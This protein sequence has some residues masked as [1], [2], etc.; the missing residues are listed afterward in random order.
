VEQPVP[1][2]KIKKLLILA[3]GGITMALYFPALHHEFLAYDDQQYVTENSH[4]QGGLTSKG[5]VWAFGFH[6]SNWHPA[7]WISHMLDC[8]LYGLNPLGHHLT[9]MLLHSANTVMLFL[10]L[11]GMTGTL[12]RS[13]AVAALFAWH[14]L[15]VESVAW[16]AER[17]DVLCAFFSLV[18]FWAYGRYV[19]SARPSNEKLEI[20][21]PKSEG[22][23]KSW[24]CLTL[25]FFALALMSK[26]MVVT[27]PFVLLLLDYWPL[28]RI[29]L[30]ITNH[31]LLF[32]LIFEKVPFLVLSAITCV[33][34]I[35]AQSQAYAVVSTAGLPISSRVA[36][37]LLSYLHYI[38]ALFWP[39]HLAVYYPYETAV[40]PAG[41]IGAASV[42]ALISFIAI[43]YATKIPY[44]LVG[45]LWFLGMLVPVI[46]LVQVGEQAWA[47][48]YTYLPSIGLFIAIV[49]G[50]VEIF[51]ARGHGAVGTP[52]PTTA[53]KV[54]R[55]VPTA[56]LAIGLVIASALLTFTSFQ[57]RLWKNTRTLFEHTAKVTEKNYMAVTLLGSLLAKEGKFDEAIDRYKTALSWKRDYPE[58][59][60]FLGNAFD[61]Q[62]K[63][64]AAIAEYE[65][66]LLFKPIHE[67]A[68]VF[69]GAALAKQ[70]KFEEAKSHYLA[71][72]KLNP[73]SGVAHNNLAKVLQSEGRSDD[74]MEH[75]SAAVKFDPGLAQVHN[76][77]GVLLLA[78]GK[79]TEGI[80]ELREALRLK[81]GDLET[82][83]NLALALNQ[84]EQWS[85]A[86]E[87]LGKVLEKRGNDANAHYQ[88]ALTLTHSQ[89]TREAMSHF[90]SA[91]LIQP[92]FPDALDGLSWILATSPNQNFRNGTEAV[93]MAERACQLTSRKDAQK[94]K[95]LAAG[96]AE[97]GRFSEA[98]STLQS[99]ISTTPNL[100]DGQQMLQAF[101]ANKPW[102]DA[103]IK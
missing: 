15:H 94:L 63:V 39:R 16:V 78:R 87:L 93:R 89:R 53:A 102:R 83:Y 41:I 4:V 9:N 35:N 14:P 8:Q 20:R 90:A 12:W 77:L 74:A 6:A 58:A 40:S 86:A 38:G 21:N 72:L 28:R 92:D 80:R 18:T 97:V 29:E 2:P 33:L 76:N 3:L 91:L 26:P 51:Q 47:D 43:R 84:A 34:T 52:R 44:L 17:K 32:R 81:P 7:A 25:F 24:Y 98:N 19:T 30:P 68:H 46:G 65:Q 45:W 11:S 88:F 59:H 70:R 60:F 54:G 61:Q 22:N 36:H 73:V 49:W 99:A 101:G 48:R 64:D 27:L 13:A 79:T 82:E 37:A 75:Y 100:S 62:G 5:L 56:P 96:Y 50:F 103:A 67:Q 1:S 23:P 69:L 55:G 71:A 85:E 10:L 57:L 95:T 42:L 66:A 31:Q